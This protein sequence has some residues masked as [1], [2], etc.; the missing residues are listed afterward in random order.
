MASPGHT[1]L[2]DLSDDERQALQ[3]RARV[4]L[5]RR[6]PPGVI[7]SL[8]LVGLVLVSTP[9]ATEHTALTVALTGLL[10]AAG[11]LRIASANVI[12]RTPDAPPRRWSQSLDLAFCL[13]AAAWSGLVCVAIH[14]YWSQEPMWM[15]LFC[16][17]GVAAAGAVSIGPHFRLARAFFAIL[18]VPPMVTLATR[19]TFL[20]STLVVVLVAYLVFMLSQVRRHSDWYWRSVAKTITIERLN[21][22]L[23][24]EAEAQRR[25]TD[26]ARHAAQA[27]DTFLA[28][29]S[30]EIRTPLNGVLGSAELLSHSQLQPEQR[31]LVDTIR[32]SAG[33]LMAILD[34]ILDLSR[35]SA[36]RLELDQTAFPVRPRFQQ[37]VDLLAG[38]ASEKGVG[39]VLQVDPEVPV[40]IEGDQH[41]LRQVVLNLLGNAIKFTQ[42]GTVLVRLSVEAEGDLLR[43][44]VKDSGIGMSPETQARIF[45]AFAQADTSTTRKYGG[46][47]L[48]LSISRQLVSLMGGQIGVSSQLGRGSTF[49]FT[50]PLVTPSASGDTSETSPVPADEADEAADDDPTPLPSGLRV[51]VAD[52]NPMNQTLT[53]RMLTHLGCNHD[54]V[55]DGQQAIDAIDKAEYDLVLMDCQMPILDGYDA[56]RLIRQQELWKGIGPHDPRRLPVVALTAS[57][58]ETDRQRC[59]DAGMDDYMSKPFTMEAL[60]R[61]VAL[62]ARRAAAAPHPESAT[63]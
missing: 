56:V 53:A 17:S 35:I 16:G 37:I 25:A 22:R 13:T 42:I 8:V 4:S 38:R 31:H 43:V 50:L 32:G 6:A 1:P 29:M 3:A 36:G 10:L 47:G 24:E 12:L 14:R 61:L 46:T 52:D 5:A 20:A 51:L 21:V 34:Q 7:G 19:G 28:H 2:E 11:A 23:T 57:A 39:I 40:V 59:F 45:E 62:R 48:G 58:M 26:E 49:W 44:E 41:R 15:L 9:L 60:G 55:S 18:M 27:R 63:T 30:H 33:G 54:M